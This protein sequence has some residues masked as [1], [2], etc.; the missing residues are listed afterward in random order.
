VKHYPVMTFRSKKVAIAGPGKL[1]VTGDLTIN[2]ITRQ[3]VLEVDGPMA[4]ARDTQG[5]E[6][7]RVSA[8]ARIGRKEFGILYSPIM[9]SGARAVS[10]DVTINLE[11]ELIRDQ[12]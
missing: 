12:N 6:K 2:A 3:V 4:P 8:L 11:I 5:R 9:Q 1:R 7:V 10:D